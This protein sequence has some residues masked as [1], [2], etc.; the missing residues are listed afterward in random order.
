M[1]WLLKEAQNHWQK[2]WKW[3]K[4]LLE[5]V[6]PN[7]IVS[8]NIGKIFEDFM[9]FEAFE[10]WDEQVGSY[11]GIMINKLLES[12]IIRISSYEQVKDIATAF[13][14]REGKDFVK[15]AKFLKVK[16]ISAFENAIAR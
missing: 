4:D 9:F 13:W 3:L 14:Q 12:G 11:V 7:Y 8:Q 6:E 10:Y 15:A 1:A 2:N 5:F 16:T